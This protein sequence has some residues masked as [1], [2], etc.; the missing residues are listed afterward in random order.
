MCKIDAREG[1]ECL[2]TIGAA[3]LEIYRKVWRGQKIAPATGARVKHF[4]YNKWIYLL[5]VLY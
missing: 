5:F 4:L 3:V 1:T 2:L